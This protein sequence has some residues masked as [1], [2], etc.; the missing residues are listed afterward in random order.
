MDFGYSP[1]QEE[2]RAH[3]QG[4][5]RNQPLRDEIARV[6]KLTGEP[7]ERPLYRMLG[8]AGLLGVNWPLEYGGQGRSPVELLIVTEELLRA[9]IHDTLYVNTILTAGNLILSAGSDELKL[10]LLPGMTRG[11]LFA[12]ILYSEPEAGSDLGALTTSA[13]A[14]DDGGFR[15]N[16]TKLYN[17]KSAITDIGLCAARTS[18]ADSKYAGITLFVIDMRAPGVEVRPLPALP[19]EQFSIVELKDVVVREDDAV[20]GV[21]AGW[22]VISQGLPLERTGLDFALRAEQWYRFGAHAADVA[23]R[24]EAIGRYG[25]RVEAAL[26]LSWRSALDV[27]DGRID[28]ARTAAAKWYASELAAELASWAVRDHGLHLPAHLADAVDRA[29]REAPG[30]TLAGGT[31]EMMLQM[32]S[33]ALPDALGEPA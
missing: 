4:L 6:R 5:F 20:G 30:L 19:A 24:A 27:V 1:D 26:L 18:Q 13:T 10:R 32:L 22:G 31:S 12:S 23:D 28:H 21:G 8:E 9:G 17:L 2:F 33:S 15:L 7:D 3:V 29:Y 14:R 16:G 25:A 11:E